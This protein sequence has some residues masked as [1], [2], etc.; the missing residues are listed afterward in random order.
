M[1]SVKKLSVVDM[2]KWLET[3]THGKPQYTNPALMVL[4]HYLIKVGLGSS[5][6]EV[7]FQSGETANRGSVGELLTKLVINHILGTDLKQVSKSQK[8]ETDLEIIGTKKDVAKIGLGFIPRG[9][10]VKYANT[11]TKASGFE[12]SVSPDT[13]VM[14]LGGASKAVKQG[15]YLVKVKDLITDPKTGK[16]FLDSA[17]NG[18][19]MHT[20]NKLV[21]FG[22]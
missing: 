12:K 5:I 11:N 18:K 13:L 19:R 1:K 7:E 21:G 6:L 14:L 16:I 9:L 17:L 8:G 20:L 2:L 3:D 4:C 22:D 15:Y 10:E